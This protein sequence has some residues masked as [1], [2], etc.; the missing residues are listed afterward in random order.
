MEDS[1]GDKALKM[2]P[3]RR[4]KFI[5]VSISDYCSILNLPECLE[6]IIQANKLAS[7]LCDL[8]SDFIREKE[9]RKKRATEAE[10]NRRWKSEE[11]QVRE[12]RDRL[13]GIESF[14]ALV[15]SVLT[16]G[17]DHIDNLKSKELQVLLLLRRRI[18]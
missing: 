17:M 2:L 1:F 16:F 13:R 3:Q 7:V 15:C 18:V 5:Y 8:E 4:L 14:E 9:D 10:E 6:Q 11:N 12:N